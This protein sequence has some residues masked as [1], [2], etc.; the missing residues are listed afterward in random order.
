MCSLAHTFIT[1]RELGEKVWGG[2]GRG[3]VGN[4]GLMRATWEDV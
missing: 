3:S 4:G 2:E 1:N